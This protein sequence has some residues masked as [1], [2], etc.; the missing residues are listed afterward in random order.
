MPED[1]RILADEELAAIVAR[2]AGSIQ[3]MNAAH[4]AMEVLYHRHVRPLRLFLSARVGQ[5]ADVEDVLQVVWQQVWHHLPGGFTG[6][7]FRAWLYQ[8][9]RNAVIDHHRKPRL[10]PRDDLGMRP[11]PRASSPEAG[12]VEQ[13][14]QEALRRCLEKLEPGLAALVRARLAGETYEAICSRLNLAPSRAHKMYHQAKKQLRAC[15]E[16]ERS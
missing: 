14:R 9:A 6:G 2:R 15:V 3:A 5:Q 1:L 4:A 8:I 12:L 13:A 7:N 11:D 16:R 10:E